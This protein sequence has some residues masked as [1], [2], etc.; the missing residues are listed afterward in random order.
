MGFTKDI[1]NYLS[2]NERYQEGYIRTSSQEFKINNLNNKMI[3][4]TNDAVQKK[5]EGY[6]KFE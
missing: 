3:H 6:G 2:F 4:L 1:G 5:G